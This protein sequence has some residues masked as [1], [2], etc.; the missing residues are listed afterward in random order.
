M[1]NRMISTLDSVIDRLTI[2]FAVLS[3]GNHSQMSV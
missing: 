2:P 3:R 1:L